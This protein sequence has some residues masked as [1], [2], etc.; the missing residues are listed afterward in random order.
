MKGSLS[1]RKLF[2]VI[3][4]NILLLTLASLAAAQHPQ[5][6]E[7]QIETHSQRAHKYLQEEK[8]GLALAQYRKIIALDPD[9]VDAHANLGV[10]LFYQG[11]YKA[12]N[13][14]LR[15]ALKLRPTLYKIQ[16]LLGM[17]ERRTGEM[18]RAR[19]DLETAFSE[20]RDE[21]IRVQS[22]LELIDLYSAADNLNKAADI[23]AVLRSL[24]PTNL[25]ILYTAYQIYSQQTNE[26]IVATAMVAPNSAEMHRIMAHEL[27]RQGNRKGAIDQ[28]RKALKLDPSLPGL[29]F[30]L[31]ELLNASS[32]PD[33]QAQAKGEYEKALAVDQFDEKSVYRLGQIAEKAGDL[34]QASADFSRA[35]RMQPNDPEAMASYAQVLLHLNQRQEAVALLE[36]S[37]KLDPSSPKTHYQLSR[38]YEQMSRKADAKQQLEEF[39]KY[40]KEKD[41]LRKIFEAMWVNYSSRS[42]P[43]TTGSSPVH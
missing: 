29:H 27:A 10:L 13:P 16:A 14:Q 25:F 41:R 38:V 17:S 35:L 22:G 40:T 21:K 9:N 31:A 4:V 8:P 19:S 33:L 20:L 30:E 3:L 7:Q 36:R 43:G 37:V 12:A 6:R 32:D 5:D 42:L 26:V 2:S 34:R 23:V 1:M 18:R 28:Y 39:L 24:E 11:D 15:A